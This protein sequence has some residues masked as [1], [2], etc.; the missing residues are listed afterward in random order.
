[1]KATGRTVKLATTQS[2]RNLDWKIQGEAATER[3]LVRVATLDEYRKTPDFAHHGEHGHAPPKD[4]TLYNDDFT[5]TQPIVPDYQWGMVVDLSRCTG[6][7][8]CVLSCQAENNIP[9]VGKAQVLNQREMHWM[10]IDR[11]YEGDPAHPDRFTI[12]HGSACTARTPRASWSA[13]SRRRCMTTKGLNMMVYNRCVGTRYCSN[14]CPYKVRH[15]N[16]L[17]YADLEDAESGAA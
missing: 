3:D 2:H 1:M 5:P 14:N 9:V 8:A 10:E 4:E 16:F 17:Q 7:E 11:Y 13:R 6:C 12:S 15:F